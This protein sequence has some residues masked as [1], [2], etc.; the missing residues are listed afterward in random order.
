[1]PI[2]ATG[3]TK[4]PLMQAARH[5]GFTLLELM[6]VMVLI[7]IILTFVVGSVGDGGR[8]DRIKREAQRIAA[9]VELVGEEAV[10]RSALSGMRVDEDGYRFLRWV[11]VD[12]EDGKQRQ[13][14][15]AMSEEDLLRPRQIDSLMRLQLT[16]EGFGITLDSQTPE[17]E[18]GEPPPQVIFMPSGEHTPFELSLRYDDDNSGYLLSAPSL[19]SVEQRRVEAYR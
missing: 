2:S 7:G 15:Q 9:L 10:L 13:E 3:V 5:G 4:S 6:V 17:G 8:G 14:W 11:T 16:V 1:M 19:G 18:E 12:G